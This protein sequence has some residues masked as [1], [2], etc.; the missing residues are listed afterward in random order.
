MMAYDATLTSVSAIRLT[1]LT[2]PGP[3]AVTGEL[4]ALHG[5]HTVLGAS[6]PLAFDADYNTSTTGSNP[7]G[8]AIPILSL[9]PDA[10]SR[11][12]ALAWPAGQ[13]TA[14]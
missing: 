2:Q 10:S 8:K 1:T 3:D 9:N 4:G 6:G 12:L 7:I 11:F 14:Y 5:A 13:P